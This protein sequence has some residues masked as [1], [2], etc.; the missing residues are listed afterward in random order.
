MINLKFD[1]NYIAVILLCFGFMS[2]SDIKEKPIS[3]LPDYG[4][5]SDSARFYFLKG[6]QEILDYGRW[7]ESEAA[8]RKAVE[9]D[10]DW[11]LG[12]SLVGRITRNLEEREN[13][14][15]E[16]EAKKDKADVPDQAI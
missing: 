1:N 12:K 11:L 9:F 6:W 15:A 8:F 4:T 10:P 16:L 13:L 2:C 5:D 3:T 14:L 7:T